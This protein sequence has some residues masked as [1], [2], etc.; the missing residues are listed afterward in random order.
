MAAAA[1]KPQPVNNS[2]YFKN[3]IAM[4]PKRPKPFSP[5]RSQSAQSKR[6]RIKDCIYC[7]V[8]HAR[9]LYSSVLFLTYALFVLFRVHAWLTLSI[10]VFPAISVFSA[11][12]FLYLLLRGFNRRCCGCG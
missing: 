10:S 12:Q 1:S 6:L 11:V 8:P 2:R 7:I 4:P 9:L 5:Q 3:N